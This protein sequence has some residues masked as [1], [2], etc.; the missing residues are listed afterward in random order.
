MGSILPVAVLFLVIAAALIAGI[1]H[2]ANLAIKRH[3]AASEEEQRA[4]F[5]ARINRRYRP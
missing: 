4:E 1:R 2:T 3:M 5:D